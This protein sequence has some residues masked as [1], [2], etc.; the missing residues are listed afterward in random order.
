MSSN[1]RPSARVTVANPTQAMVDMAWSTLKTPEE[2]RTFQRLIGVP[3]TGT[4]DAQTLGSIEF[5]TTEGL[6]FQGDGRAYR[7]VEYDGT[8]TDADPTATQ[9]N[10]ARAAD[11]PRLLGTIYET[12]NRLSALIGEDGQLPNT[13]EAQGLVVNLQIQL[14]RLNLGVNNLTITGQLDAPTLA[15]LTPALAEAELNQ[16]NAVIKMVA[17]IVENP[18]L[19]ATNPSRPETFNPESVRAF[20]SGLAYLGLYNGD[21]SG[22]MDQQTLAAM[23]NIT[24]RMPRLDAENMPVET[25]QIISTA[26]NYRTDL[27]RE[28]AASGARPP[29]NPADLTIEIGLMRVGYTSQID[30]RNGS[31]GN[32]ADNIAYS[33]TQTRLTDKAD[34]IAGDFNVA[35]IGRGAA[36]YIVHANTFAWLNN[37]ER[38]RDTNLAAAQ[39]IGTFFSKLGQG[40]A[41]AF[42]YSGMAEMAQY[43]PNIT[44]S[45][46][47]NAANSASSAVTAFTAPILSARL[48]TL[49]GV[50][51]G[52]VAVAS[53]FAMNFAPVPF[54]PRGVG[55]AD[56]IARATLNTG[57]DVVR[58]GVSGMDNIP[59]V[60]TQRAFNAAAQAPSGEVL[61]LARPVGPGRTE[62]ANN[63]ARPLNEAEATAAEILTAQR[64]PG[65][66]A[67]DGI[68]APPIAQRAT[69][70]TGMGALDNGADAAARQLEPFPTANGNAVD[71]VG[72]TPKT[73]M[74]GRGNNRGSSSRTTQGS[75]T[76]PASQPSSQAGSAARGATGDTQA[77]PF[78]TADMMGQPISTSVP[79]PAA[80]RFPTA[81]NNGVDAAAGGMPSIKT[82]LNGAFNNSGTTASSALNIFKNTQI[83][84]RTGDVIEL[85]SGPSFRVTAENGRKITAR[86][87]IEGVDQNGNV[88][89]RSGPN[90]IQIEDGKVTLLNGKPPPGAGNIVSRN[91]IRSALVAAGAIAA[92]DL[93]FNNGTLARMMIDSGRGFIQNLTGG[94]KDNYPKLG[95]TGGIIVSRAIANN[96]DAYNLISK[97]LGL[98][99]KI[100]GIHKDGTTPWDTYLRQAAEKFS[101]GKVSGVEYQAPQMLEDY[102]REALRLGEIPI[103]DWT[104]ELLE[105]AT[106][107][108]ST[109]PSSDDSKAAIDQVARDLGIPAAD[110]RSGDVATRR[111]FAEKMFGGIATSESHLMVRSILL[112]NVG[113]ENA[114]PTTT[115]PA[116]YIKALGEIPAAV[117][118]ADTATIQA[119]AEQDAQNAALEQQRSEAAKAAAMNRARQGQVQGLD[120]NP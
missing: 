31:T 54:L 80:D 102:F 12:T 48:E 30:P 97:N 52:Q 3:V 66:T 101:E 40:A 119:K 18:L 13:I 21:P 58:A 118:R 78:P 11:R 29:L 43:N 96:R 8:P 120:W 62:V 23:Q 59:P 16:R 83:V 51:Q 81:G 92:A 113:L 117:I 82:M 71:A 70:T 93:T 36:D 85:S 27:V 49:T 88:T 95:M 72:E 39:G 106:N 25:A 1:D 5:L 46:M 67:A 91:P 22:I 4:F 103:K 44:T 63:L 37:P 112:R 20:Q 35:N 15:L 109:R 28:F 73:M 107:N 9:A 75:T 26:N 34:A 108:L 10:A 116:D 19:L 105:R 94:D 53:E 55:A 115:S 41:Y 90:T 69:G 74:A 24:S 2:L 6:R 60:S 68:N 79:T 47:S 38:A 84:G 56:D 45:D 57:D 98:V 76:T 111:K 50:Q 14:E 100:Q 110:L 17:D 89:V 87:I 99:G 61:S 86:E 7:L 42:A 104:K 65:I 32:Y 64:F 33:R 77:E 114:D